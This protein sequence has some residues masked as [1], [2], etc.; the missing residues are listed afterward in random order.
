[1]LHAESLSGSF[2]LLLWCSSDKIRELTRVENKIGKK[3][4]AHSTQNG[5]ERRRRRTNAA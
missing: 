4:T 3:S 1:M 5:Q 2:A